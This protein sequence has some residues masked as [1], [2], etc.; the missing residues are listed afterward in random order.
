MKIIRNN[1]DVKSL[2]TDEKLIECRRGLVT[3][4]RF[5]CFHLR[6]PDYVILLN[7]HEEPKKFH[8]SELIGRF[9]TNYSNRDIV[10]YRRDFALKQIESFEEYLSELEKNEH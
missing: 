6:E 5:L 7:I 9:Y 8:I 3:Y 10:T 4:Y 2:K 1:K